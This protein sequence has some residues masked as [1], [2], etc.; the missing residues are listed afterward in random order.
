MDHLAAICKNGLDS[1]NIDKILL[2]ITIYGEITAFMKKY[3]Q[4]IVICAIVV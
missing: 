2:P 1:F 3:F 4:K